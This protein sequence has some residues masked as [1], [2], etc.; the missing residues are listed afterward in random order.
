[1]DFIYLEFC[2]AFDTVP[3]NIFLSKLDRCEFD[4]WTVRWMRNWLD[5]HI[6]RVVVNSSM[7]RWRSVM[8]GVPQGSILFNIFINDVDS[9]IK[10]TLSKFA[11]DTKLSGAVDTLETLQQVAHRGCGCPIPGSVQTQVG[12]G[13]EEPDLVEDGPAYGRGLD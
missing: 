2:K 6:Q 13:F 5:G 10:C 11:D 9:G 4:G 12:R 7:S 1:M 3:H 8:S